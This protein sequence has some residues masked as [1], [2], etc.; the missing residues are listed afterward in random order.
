MFS[1]IAILSVTAATLATV[2]VSAVP[3]EGIKKSCNT[4]PVQCCVY[5][6]LF[7]HRVVLKSRTLP[8]NDVHK[9]N[10]HEASSIHALLGVHIPDDTNVGFQCTPITA[11]GA[12]SGSTWYAFT[13]NYSIIF[14]GLL[15]MFI[16]L[17]AKASLFAAKITTSVSSSLFFSLLLFT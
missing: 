4:G 12:G 14:H 1:K 2:F 16:S 9:I 7:L 6:Y 17:I 3:A 11:I 5:L 13:V 8:G 10:S 15:T